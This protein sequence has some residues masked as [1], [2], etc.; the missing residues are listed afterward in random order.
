MTGYVG[1]HRWCLGALTVDQLQRVAKCRGWM[2][3]MP[4]QP[5]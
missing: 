4:G 2:L 1:R 5:S 3:R